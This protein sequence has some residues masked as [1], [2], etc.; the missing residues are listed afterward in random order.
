MDKKFTNRTNIN[1]LYINEAKKI[2]KW[3]K[4]TLKDTKPQ[5]TSPML[6]YNIYLVN[7]LIKLNKSPLVI[8][9]TL[10]DFFIF[11]FKIQP[12]QLRNSYIPLFTLVGIAYNC[13]L[14]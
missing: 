11:N 13:T 5:T 4:R 3:S 10:R 9:Q 8:L 7:K 14:N 1:K 2:Q 6:I 12:K